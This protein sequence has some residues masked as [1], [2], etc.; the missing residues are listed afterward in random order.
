[1]Y[2]DP[3]EKCGAYKVERVEYRAVVAQSAQLHRHEARKEQRGSYERYCLEEHL[4]LV[5]GV[6][7]ARGRILRA[8][9]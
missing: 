2:R 3:R 9:R 7:G 1:M 5:G 4:L 8:G 6:T